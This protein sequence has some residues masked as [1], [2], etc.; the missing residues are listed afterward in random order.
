MVA[1]KDII[2][3]KSNRNYV[4]IHTKESALKIRKTLKQFQQSLNHDFL[5]VHR[6]CIVNQL[7]IRNLKHWRNGEYLISL[8]NGFHVSSSQ[9]FKSSIE[10]FRNSSL[11]G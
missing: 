11:L 1:M 4:E 5:R 3:V 10:S 2:L 7:H 8:S 6:S 9:S